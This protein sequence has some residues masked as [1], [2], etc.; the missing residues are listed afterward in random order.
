MP[1]PFSN[2]PQP[3]IWIRQNGVYRQ[4]SRLPPSAHRKP[5]NSLHGSLPSKRCKRRPTLSRALS[6]RVSTGGGGHRFQYPHFTSADRDCECMLACSP[7]VSPCL[8]L[9][10]SAERQRSREV[11]FLCSC[12]QPF[13]S[14]VAWFW[15]VRLLGTSTSTYRRSSTDL[16]DQHHD[17]NISLSSDICLCRISTPLYP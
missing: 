6:A 2:V 9:R 11:S 10:S 16:W 13:W 4:V 17:L 3:R 15:L 14:I 5:P 12:I 8:V 1:S 7:I